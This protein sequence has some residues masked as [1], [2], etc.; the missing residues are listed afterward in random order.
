MPECL[1]F[2]GFLYN[3]AKVN[4]NEV[5]A[6][7]YDIVTQEEIEAYKKK[8]PYNIFHLEL[9]D[10]LE[11][12][13]ALLDQFLE[14]KIFVQN[15]K[16]T[17]YYHELLFT[18][19][20][21]E[22]LRQGFI[23]LVRLHSF[24]EGI[25]LP[26]ERVFPKITE[27]RF[28]L[29]KKTQFQFSQIY[30]L[31]EDPDRFTIKSLT[32][33]K[34]FYFEV[35]LEGETQRLAKIEDQKVIESVTS[36]LRDKK[37]YIADGHHRYTTALK[38]REYMQNLYGVKGEKDFNYIAMYLSPFEDP[39]LL[40]LPTHRIYTFSHREEFLHKLQFFSERIETLSLSQAQEALESIK[41]KRDCFILLLENNLWLY[42]IKPSKLQEISSQEQELS[43]LPLYNFLKILELTLG[44]SE[45]TLKER[46]EVEFLA[47]PKVVIQRVP[48]QGLGVLFPMVSPLILKEIATAGKLMPHKSTYFH[49]KILTGLVI[50][51]VSGKDL[52]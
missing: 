29:L 14:E 26:H 5:L 15:G 21:K 35:T 30:G 17:L 12:A 6:P 22:Y 42:K 4:I 2:R 32:S 13:K 33:N 18:Y 20:G 34:D 44:F 49:P 7:P 45:E 27:D 48:Q 8:S 10:T 1:A 3:Q 47:D 43:L 11:K 50:S 31:Y 40:M 9:P 23:L 19:E 46:G 51:E 24:E 41:E 39:N 36:F 52:P 38:Y 37:I 16:P 25:V 28:E